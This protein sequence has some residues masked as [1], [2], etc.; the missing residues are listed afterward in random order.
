MIRNLLFI[1][2]IICY[3]NVNTAQSPD[4]FKYQAVCR[5]ATGQVLSNQSIS[6]QISILQENASGV[7]VYTETHTTNTN[8]TTNTS[9]P[10]NKT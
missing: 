6:F 10:K 9:N 2:S 5:N 7:N 1:I 4:A 3:S 8:N